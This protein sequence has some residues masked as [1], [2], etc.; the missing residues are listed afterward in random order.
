MYRP[1]TGLRFR[2]DSRWKKLEKSSQVQVCVKYFPRQ[3]VKMARDKTAPSKLP[4]IQGIVSG[5]LAL[6]SGP[7][8]LTGSFLRVTIT[9]SKFSEKEIIELLFQIS[10]TTKISLS[11]FFLR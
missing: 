6:L 3:L 9:Q 7:I 1:T 2:T 11:F 5:G 10:A 8:I 4:P